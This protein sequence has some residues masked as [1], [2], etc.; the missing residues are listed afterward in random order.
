[1]SSF[2][3]SFRIGNKAIVREPHRSQV[4]RFVIHWFRPHD[5]RI[6]DNPSLIFSS[7][8]GHD[9]DCHVIPVF[10]FDKKLYGDTNRVQS[11]NCM[12]CGVRRA[13]FLIESVIDLRQQL[14]KYC[15]SQLL[16]GY[17]TPA[18]FFHT[19]ITDIKKYY[20]S[21][22]N[23]RHVVG[24][25][26][27]T[28]TNNKNNGD[29]VQFDIV[30]VCQDEPVREERMQVY[31]VSKVL[32]QHLNPVDHERIVTQQWGSTMFMP[33][34]MSMHSSFSDMPNDF[35][36]FV[37]KIRRCKILDPLPI[38]SYMP[39]PIGL[40]S[41]INNN[42]NNSNDNATTN[43]DEGTNTNNNNNNKSDDDTTSTT[44]TDDTTSTPNDD[45][46]S[47][48]NV[49]PL[50]FM[51]SLVDLGYTPEQISTTLKHHKQSRMKL[52]VGGETNALKRVQEYI[53]DL[54]LLRDWSIMRSKPIL[55]N[56][57]TLFSPYLAHGCISPRYINA[58]VKR[59]YKE[60]KAERA[61]VIIQS[62]LKHRD[63]QKFYC[64]KHGDGIFQKR[65]AI[66]IHRRDT[67]PKLFTRSK[68]DF[69]KWKEGRTGYPF[70]DAIMREITSTG[71]ASYRCR[72][73]AA[74]FF[75]YD[76]K[77]DWRRGA[78]YFEEQLIDFD[79]YLNWW[80]R[81]F[82]CCCCCVCNSNMFCCVES[83]RFHN[84]FATKISFFFMPVMVQCCKFYNWS[85]ISSMCSIT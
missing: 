58:E 28:D 59:C 84:D 63:Y 34:K 20:I 55:Q 71:Y 7:T 18:N 29:D 57:S 35:P 79:V 75:V 53:W 17:D 83:V 3:S 77:H 36:G 19:I 4:Q 70:V 32:R 23:D 50:T 39:F 85:N 26:R 54:D 11:S 37:K 31:D 72:L 64:I 82:C 47:S 24:S 25:P 5:L 12:K 48:T 41:N 69:T 10:V 81:Y 68:T 80:V 42:N 13:N 52:M 16:V 61:M 38:P 49:N 43:N 62:E 8:T 46:T 67:K 66:P 14:Q 76:M 9:V 21:R 74:S 60:R 1:M 65:G 73:N 27:T 40:Y 51:P 78:Q 33:K 2:T 45:S 15:Q 6:H 30:I 56:K 22:L 44:T